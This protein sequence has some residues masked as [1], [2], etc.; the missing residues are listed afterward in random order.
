MAGTLARLARL[1]AIEERS[2]KLEL[3][4]RLAAQTLAEVEAGRATAAIIAEAAGAPEDF[5][6]WLPRALAAR[7]RSQALARI[8]AN[9]SGKAQAGLDAAHRSRRLVDDALARR[10]AEAAAGEVRKAQAVIDDLV[11]RPRRAR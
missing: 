9:Q 5:A 2:A 1:R 3:A 4:R 10:R 11:Q 6:R 8:A 7:E